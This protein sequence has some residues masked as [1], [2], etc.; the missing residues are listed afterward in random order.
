MSQEQS[1]GAERAFEALRAEISIMRR[2]L[3]E[4]E[5]QVQLTRAPDTTPTLTKFGEA[6]RAMTQ[7]L[8]GLSAHP[9]LSM[10]PADYNQAVL[11]SGRAVMSD[12]Q[13]AMREAAK[14]MAEATGACTQMIGTVRTQN[15]QLKWLAWTGGLALAFGLLVSPWAVAA[16]FPRAAAS[17]VAAVVMNTDRWTAG[18]EMLGAENPQLWQD[19]EQMHAWGVKNRET[20]KACAEIALKT[21]KEQHCTL[22]IAASA[23]RGSGT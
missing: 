18:T 12:A 13:A 9:A 6:V 20:L 19:Y 8:R 5:D 3:E 22:E 17:H 16:F 14:R 1:S 4:L 10:R 15:R 11:E 2:G 21:H 23:S 7:E